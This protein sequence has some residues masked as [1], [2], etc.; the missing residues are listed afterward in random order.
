[1]SQSQRELNFYL[2]AGASLNVPANEY[3]FIFLKRAI[4]P[5]NVIVEGQTILMDVGEKRRFVSPIKNMVL[6]NPDA[7]RP[8]AVQLVVGRGDYEKLIVSGQVV[9]STKLT[10]ADGSLIDDTRKTVRLYANFR[11]NYEP[12][13]DPGFRH[14]QVNPPVNGYTSFAYYPVGD[15]FIGR[16]ATTVDRIN[17]EGGV[18]SSAAPSQ[19]ASD[20]QVDISGPMVIVGDYAYLCARWHPSWDGV[21]GH[22]YKVPVGTLDNHE[23][24]IDTGLAPPAGTYENQFTAVQYDSVA[25]E[26]LCC[27][28]LSTDMAQVYLRRVSISGLVSLGDVALEKVPGAVVDGKFFLFDGYVY[29]DA[30]DIGSGTTGWLKYDSEGNYL[31]G[32]ETD[33][34]YVSG[35][36]IRYFEQ[37]DAGLW[38]YQC[39]AYPFFLARLQ[40][41]QVASGDYH[42]GFVVPGEK[43]CLVRMYR[44]DY[45][46]YG[47]YAA[48]TVDWAGGR[49]VASGEIIKA[50]LELSGATVPDDYLDSVYTIKGKSIYGGFEVNSHRTSFMAAEIA[51]NFQNVIFPASI[52][53]TIDQRLGVF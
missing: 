5:I 1:M 8:I 3:D 39:S 28:R 40:V 26:L 30:A 19:G 44:R 31:Y 25:G 10:T 37:I 49:S 23:T 42:E 43:N 48:L 11:W 12:E 33:D 15:Y 46:E 20:I 2:E 14:E 4:R 36:T 13:I 27:Y 22:I 21:N 45:S 32:L 7:T 6:Q 29:L 16:K 9:A 52:E 41:E 34:P 51:D 18:I 53:L 35:G 17:R 38:M 47:T 50:L 24:W